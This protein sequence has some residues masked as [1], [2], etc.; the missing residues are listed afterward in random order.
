MEGNLCW[1]CQFIA[2]CC[3][4]V[5]PEGIC[6]GFKPLGVVVSQS[7]IGKWMGVSRN[8]VVYIIRKF[9]AD[10]IVERLVAHGRKVRYERKNSILRFYY[11]GKT[12]K[13]IKAR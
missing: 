7:H 6:K 11:V 3:P 9:G 12:N 5:R 4:N 1:N 2:H 10:K 13:H 8:Q